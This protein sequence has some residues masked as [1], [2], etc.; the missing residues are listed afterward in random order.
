MSDLDT[1]KAILAKHDAQIVFW[2]PVPQE[3]DELRGF[4]QEKGISYFQNVLVKM[5]FEDG[6]A[7][8]DTSMIFLQETENGF[9]PAWS[10]SSYAKNQNARVTHF[11][12]YPDP[13]VRT[14]E[15]E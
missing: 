15:S 1:F 3:Q 2:T 14:M 5:L 13:L 12:R 9:E 6:S 7:G 4:M 8:V 10:M 11:M